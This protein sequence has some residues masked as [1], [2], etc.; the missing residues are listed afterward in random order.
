M[1]KKKMLV[2]NKGR[3]TSGCYFYITY[4]LKLILDLKL[5]YGDV[6]HENKFG[7]S[8]FSLILACHNEGHKLSCAHNLSSQ[9][10]FYRVPFY[11]FWCETSIIC[12]R[13]V[14]S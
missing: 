5:T 8:I 12:I 10:R 7:M 9:L 14:L 1:H 11:P 4:G 13:S 2:A 6:G 3:L